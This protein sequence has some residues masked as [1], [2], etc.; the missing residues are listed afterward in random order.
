MR[1]P[2][3]SPSSLVFRSSV[4]ASL[5]F[6]LPARVAEAGAGAPRRRDDE[7]NELSWE[8]FSTCLSCFEDFRAWAAHDEAVWQ[9]ALSAGRTS[10]LITPLPADFAGLWVEAEALPEK[11][12]VWTAVQQTHMSGKRLNGSGLM[13]G[14]YGHN[15]TF[16]RLR[17][18]VPEAGWYRLWARYWRLRGHHASFRVRILPAEMADYTFAWQGTSL[19]ERLNHR[20]DFAEW[21]RKQPVLSRKDEA[22][23]FVWESTPLV[24]LPAGDV[25]L[26]LAGCIHDGPYTYRQVDCLVLSQDPFSVPAVSTDPV[27]AG[28]APEAVRSTLAAPSDVASRRWAPWCLR[29]G[30]VPLSGAPLEVRRL[31]QRWRQDLLARLAAGAAA[32]L[33]Q[34]RL[35]RQAT[36]DE[37]WNLVGTPAQVR[38]EAERLAG[39]SRAS[40]APWYRIIEAES[41]SEEVPGWT[42]ES[43][44]VSGGGVRMRAHYCDGRAE[45]SASVDVPHAGRF[46]LWVHHSRIKGY[47]NIFRVRL[48]PS[49][50]GGAAKGTVETAY[51]E[52]PVDAGGYRMLWTGK[53]VELGAGSCR[54]VLTKNRGK[55]PYAYRHVDRILLTDDPE[56]VPERLREPNV[57][58]AEIKEW[59][60]DGRVSLAVWRPLDPWQGFDMTTSRPGPDDEVMPES[61]TLRAAPG[62]TV[63]AL[64]H[65]TNPAPDAVTLIPDMTGSAADRFAWRVVA[66]VLSKPFGW[67]PMP[68]L[69]RRQVTVP[70]CCTASLWLTLDAGGVASGRHR[71]RLGIGDVTIDLVAEIE[72]L[73][74]GAV[75]RPLVGG[76]TRPYPSRDAWETFTDV[77]L[78][79]IHG[80]LLP[81]EEM[82]ALGIKLLN[83]TFGSPKDADA[84]HR[85]VAA[86]SDMGLGYADWSWEV[87]DE[88]GD[89][90]AEKWAAGAASV[91]R[92]DPHVRIWCNPGD[93]NV[94]HTD[95]I[96]A[97]A[98]FIDVFCPF[99]N[100]FGGWPDSEHAKLVGSVGGT[101]LFYTTPCSAEKAPHAP[102]EM[103]RLGTEALRL[104][105]H[106]WDLFC[107]KNYYEY[108]N[109]PWDDVH[110][111]HRD[112][113]VSLYPGAWDR[114][115]STRNLEA[116]RE[117]V[118]L[119][120][121]A[122][123]N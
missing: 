70:P 25:C 17:V 49:S 105:R 98:P 12:P 120:R 102:M 36:F 108:C 35:A 121:R 6:W 16:T 26:E 61:I 77:G 14:L 96:R 99:I 94:C 100:H 50:E 38:E 22:T 101:A 114:A 103:L 7:P 47:T 60:G 122:R 58:P 82:A 48:E 32:E 86:T 4:L 34:K 66:Y 15:S 76:W 30:V 81:K 1:P 62:E 27:P 42:P 72:T 19:G 63:S 2:T 10:G 40:R 119:W 89:K 56:W 52:E 91:R 44:S 24:E 74:L 23:G 112:Q 46:R 79:V 113:A 29:P 9:E 109:S 118:R 3:G 11:P 75:P 69:Y 78:N 20:F 92:A 104:G 31:W 111:Y 39:I 71:V 73:D 54:V 107:L 43:N 18:T 117:A 116:L 93:A 51:G 33:H 88:P 123:A 97:M 115:I 85:I 68:L 28:A 53:D 67:Q 87:F 13:K 21:G 80:V 57:S 110:A 5:L 64:L 65:L 90:T 59:M 95:A 37:R 84:V 45:V 106:G 55:G 8:H 41:M 83:V